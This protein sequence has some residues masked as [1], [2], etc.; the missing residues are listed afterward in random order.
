MK[1]Y[2]RFSIKGELFE[3]KTKEKTLNIE[4][5]TDYKYF[6]KIK[7]NKYNYIILYNKDLHD[8][9]ITVLPFYDK[10]IYGDFLLFMIDEDEN[11]K[12]ITESK[13]LKLINVNKNNIYEYSSDDF[14]LSD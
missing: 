6:E 5:Y 1:S 3:L 7:H 9:N 12:S 4:N 2:L 14:N 13:F 8:K 10:E 11:L